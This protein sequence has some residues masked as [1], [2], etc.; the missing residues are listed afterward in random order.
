MKI[1]AYIVFAISTLLV[2]SVL[3]SALRYFLIVKT[4]REE[5]KNIIRQPN[6]YRLVSFAI[7]GF[8]GFMVAALFW[9]EISI[10]SQADPV[11]GMLFILFIIPSWWVG[12]LSFNWKV[13]IYDDYF[14]HTNF[15][16]V[17]HR[18]NYDEIEI[19]QY[20]AC[21]RIFLNGKYRF[22]ISYLQDN[23]DA[24]DVARARYKHRLKQ[25]AKRAEKEQSPTKTPT[26]N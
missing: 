7:L 5:T 2:A 13:E 12:L 26:E 16:G 14:V 11:A 21:D 19:R 24:I 22:T 1:A 15:I 4:H 9:P 25:E 3:F 18:Y 8:Y 6:L 23:C 20:N 17:K 10:N